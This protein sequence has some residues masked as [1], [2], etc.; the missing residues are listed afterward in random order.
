MDGV[1]VSYEVT[2]R[3]NQPGV[4]PESLNSTN[5][6]NMTLTNLLPSSQYNIT[7]VTIGVKDLKSSYVNLIAYTGTVKHTA[8]HTFY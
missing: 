6:L 8:K 3:S 2:C 5:S 4:N 7:V 1:S